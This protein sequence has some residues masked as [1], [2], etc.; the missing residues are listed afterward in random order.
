MQTRKFSALAHASERLFARK[1]L[2][3]DISDKEWDAIEAVKDN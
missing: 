2:E 3:K 1:A